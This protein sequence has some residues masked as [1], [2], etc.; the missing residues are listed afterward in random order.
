MKD[1]WQ[2][3]A[4]QRNKHQFLIA[5]FSSRQK[6]E[7]DPQ[8]AKMGEISCLFIARE[9]I[10]VSNTWLKSLNIKLVALTR[11]IV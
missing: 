10:S 4:S 6:D 7:R 11:H 9:M 5:Y 1:Q 8:R 2:G 3:I